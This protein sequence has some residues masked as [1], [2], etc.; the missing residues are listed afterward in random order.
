[1]KSDNNDQTFP[2]GKS[3]RLVITD[4]NHRGEGVGKVNNFTLF[5]DGALPGE[6][7]RATIST[8]RGRFANAKQDEIVNS[9]PDRVDSHCPYFPVCGGCRLQHF[10]YSGQLSWKRNMIAQTLQ[11]IANIE[12]PVETVLGMANPWRYRNKA[13]IHFEPLE[14]KILAGFYSYGSRKIVDIRQCPVQ[15]PANEQVINAIRKTLQ[16]YVKRYGNNGKSVLPVTG[17]VIRASYATGKCV[18]AFEAGAGRTYINKN[19]DLAEMLLRETEDI[20]SGVVLLHTSKKKQGLTL[21]AGKPEL[22]E[23]IGSLRYRV[24][25]LSFFQVNPQQTEIL[26]T[27]AAKLAG[28]SKTAYDLYC[29]TGTFSLYLSAKAELVVASD[30]AKEAITDAEENA[31]L[32]RIDNVSFYNRSAESVD[33]LLQEGKRPIAVYLNP[34]RSGCSAAVIKSVVKADPEQIIYIS[35]NPATLARDIKPLA[36][37]GYRVQFVQPVDM[38]PHT[39]H[40]EAI[41]LMTRSGLS[42]KK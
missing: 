28:K 5:V 26:Y 37:K 12:A 31:R 25:P 6:T 42:D 15:H 34:P 32:N 7:V 40:V 22:E 30:S 1:M 27:I 13:R 19:K 3:L 17:A 4:L 24:S 35:C 36:D 39:T 11:R 10:S 21:L 18:V 2:E 16:T 8:N 23:T 41:I 29:G 33:N 20:I 9:V 14:G 38:F